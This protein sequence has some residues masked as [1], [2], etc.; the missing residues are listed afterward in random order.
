MEE[1]FLRLDNTVIDVEVSAVPYEH[2]GQ[3]GALVFARDITKRKRAEDALKHDKDNFERLVQ[4]RTNQLVETRVELEKTK[5]L[6]DIGVLAATVAHELRNPLAAIGI[7]A[8]NIRRK[9]KNGELNKHLS[10]IEKKIFESDQIINNLLFYSRLKP[11]HYE[12]VNIADI[13]RESVDACRDSCRKDILITEDTDSL[14]DIF[15]EA[16][17]F[18]IREVIHNILNNA[19]DAVTSQGGRIEVKGVYEKGFVKFI[20]MDN[21]HGIAKE[22][23]AKVSDPFFTTKA[24]G[25]GLGLSVCRQIVNFHCGSIEIQSEL[26]KGT[27]VTVS[28]PEKER[29]ME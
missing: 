2:K 23:L 29:K 1:K 12:S 6:S 25:T 17:P 21:G 27:V 22:S 28:L 8:Y 15:I 3:N 14:K 5:R 13:I 20:V 10:N 26:E 24:K 16:D 18:Q 19:C 11:P 9:A 7:A 4:E